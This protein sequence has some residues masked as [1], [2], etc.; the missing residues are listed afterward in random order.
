MLLQNSDCNIAVDMDMDQA[1]LSACLCVCFI[2][3]FSVNMMGDLN[4]GFTNGQTATPQQTPKKCYKDASTRPSSTKLGSF[5]T[6][7][8][9]LLDDEGVTDSWNSTSGN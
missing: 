8:G 1:T 5:R 6:R 7:K 2:T 9:Y 3:T 4:L